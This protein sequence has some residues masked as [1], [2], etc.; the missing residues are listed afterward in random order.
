MNIKVIKLQNNGFKGITVEYTEPNPREGRDAIKTTKDTIR[1]P[2]HL[3]LEKPFKD[4]R[5]HLLEIC[6]IVRGNMDKQEIDYTVLESEV[7]GIKI[8]GDGFA[9]LGTKE[10]FSGKAFKIETPMVTEDDGYEHYESVIALLNTIVE[11]TKVYMRGEVNVT[12]DELTYR[13]VQAGKQKG[14]DIDSFNA[15]SAEEKKQLCSDI[16][17]K[18]FGMVVMGGDDFTIEH[19][20]TEEV[21]ADFVI[22]S[23]DNVIELTLP[24]VAQ[25]VKK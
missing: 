1:H 11:E 8:D 7:T 12:D 2:I 25:K 5:F 13:W 21:T 22:N 4:L 9:I 18:S 10:V 15:L 16:L 24:P 14:F 19:V 20:P 6:N 3:G 17:E 23:N